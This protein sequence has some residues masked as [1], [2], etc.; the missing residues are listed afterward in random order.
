[1]VTIDN[2]FANQLADS[3]TIIAGD[4]TITVYLASA[5]TTDARTLNIASG[6]FSNVVSTISAPV[7]SINKGTFVYSGEATKIYLYSA[8]SGINIYGIQVAS[9]TTELP[10]VTPSSE[11]RKILRDGQVLIVRD[12]KTF[13]L[14][15]DHVE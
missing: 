8:N 7:G 14:L 13:N 6:S 9:S 15:G 12:G 5:S 10:A 2:I 1:M 11:A 3:H 4:C